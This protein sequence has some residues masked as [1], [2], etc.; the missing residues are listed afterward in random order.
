MSASTRPRGIRGAHLVSIWVIQE[1]VQI[2]QTT[3]WWGAQ[4]DT[5]WHIVW[6]LQSPKPIR[7]E[8]REEDERRT[9]TLWHCATQVEAGL[10]SVL[11]DNVRAYTS[12]SGMQLSA[13]SRAT[14]CAP[15]RPYTLTIWGSFE[16]KFT[17]RCFVS[18]DWCMFSINMRQL[19]IS[20]ACVK[21]KW[22]RLKNQIKLGKKWCIFNARWSLFLLW[23]VQFLIQKKEKN[24]LFFFKGSFNSTKE[25]LKY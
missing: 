13:A 19:G 9:A 18:L 1:F 12:N 7:K 10:L 2:K 5:K 15:A 23:K 24:L 25:I 22:L 4:Q 20:K 6:R 3:I 21:K 14:H 11:R 8:N 17:F 16:Q